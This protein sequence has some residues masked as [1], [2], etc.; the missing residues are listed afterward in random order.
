LVKDKK[1]LI[2][3]SRTAEIT[4]CQ[5]E[6]NEDYKDIESL[7][8][9]KKVEIKL[10]KDSS[11]MFWQK[12]SSWFLG[13]LLVLAYNNSIA[14]IL[15]DSNVRKKVDEII[16]EIARILANKDIDIDTQVLLT[17]IYAF[18]DDFLSEYSSP[19]GC[20]ALIDMFAGVDRFECPNLF[21]LIGATTKKY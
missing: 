20:L 8:F 21:E 3:L 7:L 17:D 9:N 5:K 4:L 16:K 15:L 14:N 13:N 18:P 2:L 10:R 12:V 6:D 11:K 1:D 19:R